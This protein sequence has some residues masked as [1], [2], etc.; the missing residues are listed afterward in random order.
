MFAIWAADQPAKSSLARL[1]DQLHHLIQAGRPADQPAKTSPARL[2]D[3]LKPATS[4]LNHLKPAKQL[5]LV[6]V[7]FFSMQILHK[8]TLNI[9]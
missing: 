3:K 5:R 7:V 6:L 8:Q 1:G 9:N 4:S 2:R